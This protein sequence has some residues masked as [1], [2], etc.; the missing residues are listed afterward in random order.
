MYESPI[1]TLPIAVN[2]K[3]I[4]KIQAYLYS[5]QLALLLIP[6]INLTFVPLQRESIVMIGWL[7]NQ[8]N[9]IFEQSFVDSTGLVRRKPVVPT[10]VHRRPVSCYWSDRVTE[11]GVC[12][13]SAVAETTKINTY[14]KLQNNLWNLAMR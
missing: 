7:E 9:L 12:I 14:I 13:L 2:N 8:G 1:G 4:V 5:N 3:T 10:P 6:Y 11:V